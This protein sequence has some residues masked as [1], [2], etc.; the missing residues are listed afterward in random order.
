MSREGSQRHESEVAMS[1]PNT[2]KVFAGSIPNLYETYLVPL[3]FEPYAADMATRLKTRPISRLLEIA[4]GTGV[5][6]RAL[7]SELP[8]S[9]AIVATDLNQAML[10]QAAAVGTKR[11]V[12]WRQADAMQLPFQDAAFD[13]VVCQFG[14]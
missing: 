3:I 12:E 6:T 14:A 8:D 7:A 5:V 9:A 13:A 4:A 10:D 11:P 1:T 2:D